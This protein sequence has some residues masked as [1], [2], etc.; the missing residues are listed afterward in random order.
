MN[1]SKR[2]LSAGVILWL[3]VLASFVAVA[4]NNLTSSQTVQVTGTVSAVNVGVYS[5]QACAVNCTAIS[6]GNVNPGGSKSYAV[7]VKNT[8]N[9][10]VTLAL[11][12]GSWIPTSAGSLLA[13]TWD[14]EGYVLQASANVTATLVL[15][16]ESN[17]GSLTGF[18]YNIVVTG[19]Q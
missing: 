18:S 15:S 16:A 3:I 12:T 11:T 5:D 7:Y 6:W 17:T 4:Y 8:G 9:V 10:A 19:T 2:I 1:E 13:Q 14:R